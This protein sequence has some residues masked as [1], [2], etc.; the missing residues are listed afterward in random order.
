MASFKQI[1]KILF[2]LIMVAGYQGFA[3]ETGFLI[4]PYLLDITETSVVVAFHLAEP[5][6]ARVKVWDNAEEKLFFSEKGVSH[7]VTITGLKPGRSYHYQVVC[8]DALIQTGAE[9]SSYQIKTACL[10]GESFSFVVFGDPR[11]GDTMT[12]LNHRRIIEQIALYEPNFLLVLGDMVDD[13][14]VVQEWVNFF[15][16]ENQLLRSSA[17]FPV[18]GDN[19]YVL[20]KGHYARFFPKL[21]KGYYSFQW[22]GIQFYGLNAWGT[23]AGQEISEFNQDSPQVEWLV[24]QLQT[25]VA[26]NAPFR[27]VFLHDPVYIS[28]GRSSDLLRE[29]LVPVF[30]RYRVD[31]VFASWHLYERSQSNNTSYII[32]GGAG[33]ELIWMNPNP[34]Y[35]S[36][37]EAREYHFCRV[38]VNANALTIRSISTDGTVLDTFSL[39]PRSQDKQQEKSVLDNAKRLKKDLV[40]NAGQEELPLILFS[41]DCQFCK[42]L[43][44]EVLP[45]KALEEGI[46]L[47]VSYFDLAKEGSY[48]LFL[49]AGMEFGRQDSDVPAIFIGVSV[50]GGEE[51]VLRGLENEIMDF[52]ISPDMY[53]AKSVSAFGEV[54]NTDMLGEEAFSG[55]TLGLVFGAGFLDGINPCAFTTMIFLIS[56][57]SVV[58][59]TRNRMLLT[60]GIFT[61]SVF[62]TYFVIGLSYFGIARL[63]MENNGVTLVING[64]LL[65]FVLVLAVLSLMDYFKCRQ[66]KIKEMVLK[67]P[68]KLSEKIK[69]HIRRFARHSV[70]LAGATF[71]LGIVISGME[72]T[73]TGQVYIPIVTMISEPQHRAMAVFYLLLYNLAF[74]I[75]LI[76]I[77]LLATFGVT[78]RN[79][80]IF[81]KKHVA[82]VK[83]AFSALFAVMALV[84]V[85][86]IRL[87]L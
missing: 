13:G 63:I 53:Y 49:N 40:F 12:S 80:E 22:G 66:G 62:L 39:S 67:L 76:V 32:S 57:L 68:G 86:N 41:Y 16:V 10:P 31:L 42:L 43:L 54:H 48:D 21:Q 74:I 4:N 85:W 14:S 56:Y 20:G 79:L 87:L 47:R 5:M 28:R 36:Q 29:T 24:S 15:Q 61:L 30:K 2:T 25:E 8:G 19:D 45:R 6:E 50:Y 11:P 71:L 17:I 26:I 82:S 60:G 78:S 75:P 51:E 27:V 70:A 69:T 33:A 23:R 1:K 52:K 65:I 44:K 34:S 77:F 37:A 72:L 9:D 3:E 7:F 55:L 46:T 35:P 59:A 84:I 38:N 73:C 18:L 81:F 64:I 83:L 58:G